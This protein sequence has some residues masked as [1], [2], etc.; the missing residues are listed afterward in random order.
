MVMVLVAFEPP[1]AGTRM[2][3]VSPLESYVEV[4]L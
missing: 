3:K 4:R 2:G 1:F